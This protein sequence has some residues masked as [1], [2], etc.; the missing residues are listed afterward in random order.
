[1]RIYNCKSQAIRRVIY[2][3]FE[4]CGFI[5]LVN[6]QKR[7]PITFIKQLLYYS[8]QAACSQQIEDMTWQTNNSD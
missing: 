8:D 6:P 5:K 3:C 7:W 2:K 1:M 4:C